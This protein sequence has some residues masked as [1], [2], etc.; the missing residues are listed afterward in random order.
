[1]SHKI[2]K[3]YFDE[4]VGKIDWSEIDPNSSIN[5]LGKYQI[6]LMVELNINMVMLNQMM[7]DALGDIPQ[8]KDEPAVVICPK[9]KEE[10]VPTDIGY[11]PKCKY[12]LARYI[13]SD[14]FH[15][16]RKVEG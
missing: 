6:A 7:A 3:Q 11:C 4:I 16:G 13:K 2:G 12:D 9:C 14:A 15:L 1:M 8:G 5:I 10:V